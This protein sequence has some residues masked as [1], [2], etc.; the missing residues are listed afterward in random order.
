MSKSKFQNAPPPGKEGTALCQILA[1]RHGGLG[2]TLK[3]D[4]LI[5]GISVQPGRLAD[6]VAL[7]ERDVAFT[8]DMSVR[9][10]LLFHSLMR[11]PGTLTR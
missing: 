8:P 11:E 6:R 5:N 1:N 9:Q 10:T 3:G 2:T 7:V 4:I